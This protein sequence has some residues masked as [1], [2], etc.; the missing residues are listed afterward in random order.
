MT[1]LWLMIALVVALLFGNLWLLKR[2]RKHLAPRKTAVNRPA[3]QAQTQAAVQTS[4]IVVTTSE[5]NGNDV[6]SAKPATDAGGHSS[7]HSDGGAD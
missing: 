7:G 5:K 3:P 1:D 4:P 2:N 6:P